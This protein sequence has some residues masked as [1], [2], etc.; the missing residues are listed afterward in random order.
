MVTR[1]GDRFDGPALGWS[2]LAGTDGSPL[3]RRREIESLAEKLASDEAEHET[4]AEAL[5]AKRQVQVQT[6]MALDEIRA[7]VQSTAVRKAEVQKEWEQVERE[8]A[9]LNQATERFTQ[10]VGEIDNQ[11]AEAQRL[12]QSSRVALSD[13]EATRGDRQRSLLD[14]EEWSQALQRRDSAVSA[15]HDAKA[16]ATTAEERLLSLRTLN[17]A[18]NDRFTTL[19]FVARVSVWSEK[20]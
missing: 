13:A 9:Y 10:E 8:A 7:T 3:S 6:R 5:E 12:E 4:M 2:G 1:S 11:F 15:V 16:R 20:M 14:A 17:L 18:L 19:R